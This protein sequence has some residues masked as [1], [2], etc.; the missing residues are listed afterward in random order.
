M[1]R[2]LREHT[3]VSVTVIALLPL[4]CGVLFLADNAT[5]DWSLHW[6]AARPLATSSD[7]AFAAASTHRGVDLLYTRADNH[8][9]LAR[10]SAFRAPTGH[11][12]TLP[13]TPVELTL[14]TTG[15]IGRA[16]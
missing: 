4:L 10:Y 3:A 13:G 12:R 5:R 16:H 2:W 7:A 11:V 8:L 1:Q 9:Q 14:A 6:V 15:E